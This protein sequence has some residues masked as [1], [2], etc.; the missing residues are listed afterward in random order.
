MDMVL[1]AS[2]EDYLSL[3]TTDWGIKQPG[4][5]EQREVASKVDLVIVPGLAFT[6]NGQ[7]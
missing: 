5:Q 1:L 6:K 4:L 3:P 7:R 2:W